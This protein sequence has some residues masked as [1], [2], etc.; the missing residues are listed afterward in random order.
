MLRLQM[1]GRL[2]ADA[3]VRDAAGKKV[4]S[5]R[6]AHSEPFMDR[7]GVRQERTTWVSCS[8]WRQEGRT[9]VAQYLVRG[10]QVYLEGTPS[11]R[12]YENREGQTVAALELTVLNLELLGGKG[13]RQDGPPSASTGPQ[14]AYGAYDKP[15]TGPPPATTSQPYED[16]S[17]GYEDDLPF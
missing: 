9:G 16:P 13:E 4:I 17:E 12:T 3:E 7:Q 14:N 8:L 6:V 15:V 2:G 11:V 5:F 10:A 1:I